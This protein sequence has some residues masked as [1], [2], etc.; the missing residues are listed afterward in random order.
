MRIL[1]FFLLSLIL[2]T[3]LF[4]LAAS[5]APSQVNLTGVFRYYFILHISFENSQLPSFTIAGFVKV[6]VKNNIITGIEGD[7]TG[8]TS[9]GS[10][11]TEAL[12]RRLATM[13]L[14]DW[15]HRFQLASGVTGGE[16]MYTSVDGV[17]VRAYVVRTN[18][19][20]EYR[21]ANTG[22]YLGGVTNGET[23]FKYNHG[24]ILVAYQI[25]SILV[26]IT[27]TSILSYFNVVQPPVQ[28]VSL[29]GGVAALIILGGAV[30]T[31]VN[32]R[33]YN[34]DIFSM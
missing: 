32:W 9:S 21:E 11:Y 22:V 16:P 29:I 13:I 24:E 33:N 12:T 6:D 14:S 20:I 31:V 27:P 10:P 15:I 4:V 18:N 23:V 34:L 30:Y 17:I 1:F 26:N 25:S 19:Q 8:F 5:G 3:S 2:G 28:D 7:I